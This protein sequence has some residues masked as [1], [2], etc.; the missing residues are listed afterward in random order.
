M[1]MEDREYFS[2]AQGEGAVTGWQ[3]FDGNWHNIDE[4]GPAFVEGADIAQ[5]VT[6]HY[7]SDRGDDVYFTIVDQAGFEDYESI[8]D[9][10][11]D[12]LDVYG[13]PT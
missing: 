8:A 7:V 4:G 1:G 2:V 13:I 12:T 6:I 5:K 10:F 11:E 3:D 9:A